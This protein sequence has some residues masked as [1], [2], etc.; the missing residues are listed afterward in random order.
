MNTHTHSPDRSLEHH[1]EHPY[2]LV[3]SVFLASLIV[4]LLPIAISSNLATSSNQDTAPITLGEAGLWNA[5]G[6]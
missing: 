4:G 2:L 3:I 6:R 1:V 5:V